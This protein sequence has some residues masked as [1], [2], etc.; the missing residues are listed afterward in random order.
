MGTFYDHQVGRFETPDPARDR[1]ILLVRARQA[2]A[3][4]VADMLGAVHRGLRSTAKALATFV[5]HAGAGAALRPPQPELRRH[6]AAPLTG[7]CD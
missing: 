7:G 5:R 4:A 2:R 3:R 6:G 1:E